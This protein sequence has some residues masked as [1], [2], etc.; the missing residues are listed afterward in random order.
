MAA[1]MQANVVIDLHGSTGYEHMGRVVDHDE[2]AVVLLLSHPPCEPALDLVEASPVLLSLVLLSPQC[3]RENPGL[4]EISL[5]D[6]DSCVSLLIPEVYDVAPAIPDEHG[7]LRHLIVHN[8]GQVEN[9]PS[10]DDQDHC[11]TTCVRAIHTGFWIDTW[12]E[13]DQE[14]TDRDEHHFVDYVLDLE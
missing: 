9:D 13:N 2:I 7:P 12:E 11:D 10:R 5:V 8:H 4:A 6:Q 1:R 14:S 3:V